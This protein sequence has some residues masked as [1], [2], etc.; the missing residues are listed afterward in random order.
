MQFREEGSFS[1]DGGVRCRVAGVLQYPG[2]CAVFAD[3]NARGLVTRRREKRMPVE[4][5]RDVLFKAQPLWLPLPALK[6]WG[7]LPRPSDRLGG[8]RL[9]RPV[10]GGHCRRTHESLPLRLERRPLP[11]NRGH[12]SNGNQCPLPH[13]DE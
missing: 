1:S 6:G 4:V 9:H 5:L 12:R 13:W 7:F 8:F 3:L 11:R 2:G 10:P